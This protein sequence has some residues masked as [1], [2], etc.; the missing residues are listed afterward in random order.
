M[1]RRC[2]FR[3]VS[4]KIKIKIDHIMHHFFQSALKSM[5]LTRKSRN[6]KLRWLG[7]KIIALENIEV[8]KL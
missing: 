7:S 5:I 8:H 1:R 6:F 2:I 4:F 3:L